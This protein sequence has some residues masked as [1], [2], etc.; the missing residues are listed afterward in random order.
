MELTV[1]E[2]K[3]LEERREEIRRE[4]RE[5]DEPSYTP[6]YYNSNERR[7]DLQDELERVEAEL[8][9]ANAG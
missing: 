7:I 2:M 9:R 3:Y 1:Q 6:H 5:L 8:E 4:L